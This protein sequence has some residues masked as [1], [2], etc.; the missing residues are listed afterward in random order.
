MRASHLGKTLPAEQ[1]AK[2]GAAQLGKK[3]GPAFSAA[4]A[5]RNRTRVWSAE[6]REKISAT[7]KGRPAHNRGVFGVPE[8]TRAR[9][10]AAASSRRGPGWIDVDEQ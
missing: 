4:L 10:S 5:A 6:S 1:R 7:A 2:I 3:M 9:M 8:E